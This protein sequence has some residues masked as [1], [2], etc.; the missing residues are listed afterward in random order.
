MKY[1][2]EILQL[3]VFAKENESRYFLSTHKQLEL[4]LDPRDGVYEKVWDGELEAESVKGVLDK[5]FMAFGTKRPKGYEG[6]SLTVSDIIRVC[7][8]DWYIDPFGYVK[9]EGGIKNENVKA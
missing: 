6:H 8:N 2:F 5:V 1:K 9:L 3:E 7:G 4:G